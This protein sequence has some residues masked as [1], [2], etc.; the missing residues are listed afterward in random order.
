MRGSNTA[1][2][3]L[4]LQSALLYFLTL[5]IP[6]GSHMMLT[7]VLRKNR[8]DELLYSYFQ[9]ST[10]LFFR[11]TAAARSSSKE[12]Q[13]NLSMTVLNSFDTRIIGQRYLINLN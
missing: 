11:Q 3:H 9:N 12:I 4:F 8:R 10:V 1:K 2:R 5:N 6:C 13:K 7:T